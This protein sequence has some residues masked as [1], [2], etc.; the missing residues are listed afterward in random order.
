MEDRVV[1]GTSGWSY[2]DW[3]PR[4]MPPRERLAWYTQ[5]FAGVEVDSTFY[6][7]PGRR[8]TARWEAV[9]PPG[10]TFDVKLHRLLSRHAAPPS[11]LPTDLR[12]RATLAD[13]GKVILD[14]ELEAALCER[15]LAAVEPLSAAGKLS[16]FLL[17]LTPAFKPPD[18]EL[19]E[20]EPILHMLAPVPVAVELRH[21]AW[22]RDADATLEWFRR[23]GA[24][25]VCVDAPELDA[26]PVLPRLDAVT[27]ED[28][29]YLRA[30]GRN[31]E[32]YLRGRSA[33]ERFDWSYT[34]DELRELA[35]RAHALA[36][37]A[38]RVRLMFGNGPGAPESATRMREILGQR[39][40]DALAAADTP[41]PL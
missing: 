18:H 2:P 7:I 31:A 36:G 30:H 5:R 37:A 1:V 8:T 24:T 22:L 13:S 38:A 32:G 19:P 27:R 11:S 28:L 25:F 33:A 20:L 39:W 41:S 23:A 14:P 3:Y 29:A 16:S 26:P 6:A 21:R 40:P 17:Q 12:E 15:T 9:T 35:G 34:E 4:G 10:F